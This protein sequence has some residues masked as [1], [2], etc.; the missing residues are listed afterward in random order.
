[1]PCPNGLDIPG[2]FEILNYAHLYD[3]L[4]AAKFKYKVFL[5]E[6]QRAAECIDCGICEEHVPARDPD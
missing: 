2:N 4:A 6:G 3:D 5:Q 1:M